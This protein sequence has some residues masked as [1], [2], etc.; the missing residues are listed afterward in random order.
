MTRPDAPLDDE[1]HREAGHERT[2]RIGIRRL[3]SIAGPTVALALA[4]ALALAGAAYV[5]RVRNTVSVVAAEMAVANASGLAA[6]RP[7]DQTTLARWRGPYLLRFRVRLGAADTASTF[8]LRLSLRAASEVAWDGLLLGRNGVVG[9]T[10]GEERPGQVDWLAFVPSALA[11]PGEHV[12]TVRAS[13]H[14]IVDAGLPS[15]GVQ[16]ELAPLPVLLAA[17]WHAWLVI[18]VAFGGVLTAWLHL[19]A[20]RIST[21]RERRTRAP[22]DG[23][24]PT[25]TLL[26][27]GGA[28]QL[29]LGELAMLLVAV[30]AWRPLVGYRYDLHPI[31]LWAIL[32]LTAGVAVLLPLGLAAR[33][34][35]PLRGRRGRPRR[36]LL[37]FVMMIPIV[38]VASPGFDGA[39]LLLHVVGLLGALVVTA[40]ALRQPPVAQATTEVRRAGTTGVSSTRAGRIVIDQPPRQAALQ[41]LALL[42]VALVA[43]VL[44]PSTYIDGLHLI[45]LAALLMVILFSHARTLHDAA[46]QADARALGAAAARDRLSVALLKASI[47]PHWL[48]NTLTALQELIERAPARASELVSR[49]A[50]EFRMLRAV[51]ERTLVPALEEVALC[52]VHLASIALAQDATVTLDLAPRDERILRTVQLPPGVLHTLVENGLTHGA[53][54]NA[55]GSAGATRFVLRAEQGVEV[56]CLKLAVPMAPSPRARRPSGT[57]TRFVEA[58]LESAFPGRWHFEHGP[59]GAGP[60]AQWV[61]VLIVPVSPPSADRARVADATG[62]LLADARRAASVGHRE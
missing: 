14:H 22:E 12:V 58:S 42:V 30:E 32:F 11:S 16:L 53:L 60:G 59:H 46:A 54:A 57:G 3:A 61:S 39:T 6:W 26:P 51:S 9:L 34:G 36:T 38:I 40:H 47:H 10:R 17:P 45:A 33:F 5:Q 13:S 56:V 49:L 29:A 48:M 55:G 35:V 8:G 27:P 19:V 2:A 44:A 50:E 25:P 4:L 7:L 24:A 31:R 20:A 28:L 23:H 37:A 18:A 15:A 21:G 1:L 52:R 41:T 62:V 43:L